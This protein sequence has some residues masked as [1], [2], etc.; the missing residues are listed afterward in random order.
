MGTPALV[1]CRSPCD[2]VAMTAT[3]EAELV[4]SIRAGSVP[5]FEQVMRRYYAE[6]HAF[7]VRWLHTSSGADDVLQEL[8]FRFWLHRADLDVRTTLRAYL[9][10]AARGQTLMYQRRERS[11]SR[12]VVGGEDTT[13][14]PDPSNALDDVLAGD[15]E[16]A[17]RTAV[18]RLP[19]RT[20]LVFSLSREQELSYA[21]IAEVMGISVNTVKTQL[22]RAL[23]AVRAAAAPFLVMVLAARL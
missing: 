7:V 11:L 3:E 15:L 4:A 20:K 16:H 2:F 10:A 13:R 19:E 9:Y 12:D 8:F 14:I 22:G 21:E 1:R 5:A 18:E 17:V 6:L 23:T